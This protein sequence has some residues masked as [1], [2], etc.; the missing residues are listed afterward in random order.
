M[1][2]WD[3]VSGDLYL[4]IYKA[5]FSTPQRFHYV[6]FSFSLTVNRLN[7]RTSLDDWPFKY[8]TLKYAALRYATNEYASLKYTSFKFPAFQYA[9]LK[10]AILK[11]AMLK[12]ARS[13]CEAHL[14][15]TGV[16]LYEIWACKHILYW[17]VAIDYLLTYLRMHTLQ[18][19][20]QEPSGTDGNW[21]NWEKEEEVEEEPAVL[22]HDLQRDARQSTEQHLLHLAGPPAADHCPRPSEFQQIQR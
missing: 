4:S 20:W 17:P 1:I 22:L 12:Y 7:V 6:L 13:K 14:C 3:C 16:L 21:R 2:Q 9:V 15:V 5:P 19:N 18:I 10:Y 8:A 11:Y